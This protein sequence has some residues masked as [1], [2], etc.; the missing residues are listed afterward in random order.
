[1]TS[2]P[3]IAVENLHLTF[4]ADPLRRLLRRAAVREVLRGVSF[5]VAAGET[6]GLLGANGAGK[7]TILKT[8]AGLLAPTA[9]SVRVGGWDTTARSRQARTLTGYVLADE[10]SF[11][12]RLNAVENLEFFA[13]LSGLHGGVARRRIRTLLDRLDLASAASR[14]V[15]E[16]STG[17][18]Q[19]LAIARALLPRPRVLLMDEPARSID[20]AHAAEVWRLVREEMA[21]VD[22]C[23]VLVTHQIDEALAFCERIAVLDSGRLAF[24]TT[25]AGLAEVAAGL[26]GFTVAVRGLT[27]A[28]LAALRRRPDIHDARVASQV[29]GEQ[30]VEVWTDHTDRAL[31]PVISELTEGGATVTALQRGTPLHGVLTR[32]TAEAVAQPRR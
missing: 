7:T 14:D 1:M 30:V 8:I 2:A 31:V 4:H 26:S 21:A 6:L 29:A 11:Y 20:G 15:A 3:L 12:W 22:G 5:Q 9:G 17:M 18:R 13:A 24:D 25:A 19:R 32:L 16:Y 28:H 27:E 10:R 23:A